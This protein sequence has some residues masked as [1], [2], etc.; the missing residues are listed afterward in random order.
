MNSK[1]IELD[2]NIEAIQVFR[3]IEND[4]WVDKFSDAE[5]L[6]MYGGS[7]MFQKLKFDIA[8]EKLKIE[9]KEAFVEPFKIKFNAAKH[10]IKSMFLK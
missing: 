5:L 4:E 1:E 10:K 7:Y 6:K 3:K 9:L 8:L 2:K